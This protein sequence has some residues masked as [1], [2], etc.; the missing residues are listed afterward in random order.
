MLEFYIKVYVYVY[1]VSAYLMLLNVL[2]VRLFVFSSVCDSPECFCWS[3][4]F[5]FGGKP[6]WSFVVGAS[7]TSAVLTS[8]MQGVLCATIS[9][10]QLHKK[11]RT[12]LEWTADSFITTT[13]TPDDGRL[14]RNM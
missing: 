10:K 9:P 14:G 5:L 4:G 11:S 12:A 7:V 6:S 1:S 13:C 8:R 2:L 3:G